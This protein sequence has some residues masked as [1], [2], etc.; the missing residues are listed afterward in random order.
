MLK[1]GITYLCFATADKKTAVC[2]SFLDEIR[3]KFCGTFEQDVIAKAMAYSTTFLDF[4]RILKEEMIKWSQ[5]EHSD[6]KFRV[7]LCSV[8]VVLS[9]WHFFSQG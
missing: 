7:S 9:D 2:F 4:K 5:V 3:L 1:D 6:A 8:L